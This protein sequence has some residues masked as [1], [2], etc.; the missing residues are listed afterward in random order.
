M[1]NQDDLKYL[2]NKYQI[3]KNKYKDFNTNI[4]FYNRDNVIQNDNILDLLC[5]ICYNI[6]KDP[7]FCSSNKNSHYFCKECIDKY[8]EQNNNCPICKNNF[9]YKIKNEFEKL[10]HKLDFKCLFYNEGCTKII[11]Y[12]EYYNHINECKY[13]NLLYK[14]KIDKYN[15]SNKEFEKCNYNGNIEEIKKHF[16]LC[17]FIKYKCIFCNED[18]LQIN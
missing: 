1:D 3:D 2:L 10:L 16:K 9:E 18:I 7:K 5:P 14:C 12:L 11:N 4:Y 6:L 15:F 13:N 8:L 17:A